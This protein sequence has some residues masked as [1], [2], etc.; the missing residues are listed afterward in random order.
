MIWMSFQDA[1][2][3]VRTE[4]TEEIPSVDSNLCTT[5]CKVFQSLMAEVFKT[6]DEDDGE[7]AILVLPQ[8]VLI[9]TVEA[10]FSFSLI[11][12]VGANIDTEVSLM[13]NLMLT[14]R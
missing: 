2:S 13:V 5:C 8:D 14:V 3:F 10:I 4:C 11:W 6:D 9:E 1:I 12:S 7:Q